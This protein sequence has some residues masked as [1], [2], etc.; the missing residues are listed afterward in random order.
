MKSTINDLDTKYI[1]YQLMYLANYYYKYKY[2]YNTT[3]AESMQLLKDNITTPI[4]HICN[5]WNII[6]K[7]IHHTMNIISIKVK[8]LSIRCGIN[9]AIQV[10]N[11]R[12]III[13]TDAISAVKHIFDL[14]NHLFQLHFIA[15][16]QD[17]R[18]FFNKNSNNTISFWDCS[19]S[20]KQPPH[21]A[22]DKEIKQLKTDPIFL[23]KSSWYFSKKEEYDT[24]LKNWQ[25]NF[26]ALDYK[27]KNFLNL[28]NN[29]NLPTRP[30]YSKGGI[31]LKLI[32]HSNSLCV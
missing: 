5:G 31:W 17:L 19:S 29:D 14:S 22:V 30:T 12:Q 20:N 3:I 11:V 7:T 1:D 8:L 2:K 21:L 10:L 24:I 16:S 6:A 15:V 9:L 28:N 25:I 26:Q 32:G 13:I 23:C 27:G 18:A 4:L